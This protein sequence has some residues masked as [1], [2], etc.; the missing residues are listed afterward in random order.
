[1]MNYYNKNNAYK[2]IKDLIDE[3]LKQMRNPN[4]NE[5]SY[6]IW[7]NYS[8]K[9]LEIYTQDYNPTI[10]LNYLRVIS[11]ISQTLPTFQKIG[12]CLDYLI[13]VLRIL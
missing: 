13:G 5:D 4:L 12:L 9:I 3:G 6:R 7:V 10:I 8:Q 2:S 1:M 11:S